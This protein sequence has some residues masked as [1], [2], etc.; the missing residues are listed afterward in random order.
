[1]NIFI[2]DRN[3]LIENET[4]LVTYAGLFHSLSFFANFF[5]S[6]STTKLVL[7]GTYIA[8]AIAM[9]ANF[10]MIKIR[11]IWYI[12]C[13]VGAIAMVSIYSWALIADR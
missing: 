10:K 2:R 7:S 8:L 3:S 9:I 1:M 4:A 6:D 13:S 11:G 12:F 5:L